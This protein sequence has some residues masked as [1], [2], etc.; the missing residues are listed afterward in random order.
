MWLI[1]RSASSNG[2]EGLSRSSDSIS[3]GSRLDY[4]VFSFILPNSAVECI[5]R[6][7]HF[8]HKVPSHD[9]LC[10]PFTIELF[11]FAPINLNRL[12]ARIFALCF[13]YFYSLFLTEFCAYMWMKFI[14]KRLRDKLCHRQFVFFKILPHLRV[15]L[16]KG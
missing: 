14:A 12:S 15:D 3:S 1:S 10:F 9:V 11:K 8:T 16:E 4:A 2:C 13:G 5:S 7:A 6:Q